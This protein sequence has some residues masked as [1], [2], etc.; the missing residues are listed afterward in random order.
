[1]GASVISRPYVISV[2]AAYV[3]VRFIRPLSSGC[4]S[5]RYSIVRDSLL[6][7][8]DEHRD[9]VYSDCRARARGR[10]KTSRKPNAYV[11]GD[12]RSPDRMLRNDGDPL[13]RGRSCQN[14]RPAHS[15]AFVRT[16]SSIGVAEIARFSP[17]KRLNH[18]RCAGCTIDLG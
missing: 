16:H 12:N 5:S 9:L 6:S 14:E 8:L 13:H 2:F 10:H 7:K 17:G 4:P 11:T 18:T 15:S 3:L 1:M